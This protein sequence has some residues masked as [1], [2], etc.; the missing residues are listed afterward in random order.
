MWRQLQQAENTSVGVAGHV[1]R[2][3]DHGLPHIYLFKWLL[4]A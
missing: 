3:A 1:T 4:Q 2:M